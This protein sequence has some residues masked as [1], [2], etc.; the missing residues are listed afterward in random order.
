MEQR[1]AGYLPGGRSR[2][3][4]YANAPARE[5]NLARAPRPQPVPRAEPRRAP[6]PAERTALLPKPK[7]KVKPSW[8]F[9]FL[10]VAALY[11]LVVYNY[12]QITDLSL[13][14]AAHERQIAEYDKSITA[15]NTQIN[16][17]ISPA[18]IESRA[19]DLGMVKP[20]KNQIEYLKI[21]NPDV[22]TAL[23]NGKVKSESGF[24][25]FMD[26]LARAF[27]FAWEYIT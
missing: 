27:G 4:A 16:E 19:L 5:G 17:R 20:N 8:I 18:D 2:G 11:M 13:K 15:L 10:A 14:N 22:L 23:D 9:A 12:M 24:S 21:D 7:S 6:R 26:G 3:N 25:Y 1:T